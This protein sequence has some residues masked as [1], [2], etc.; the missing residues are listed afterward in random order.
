MTIKIE[1]S[2]CSFNINGTKDKDDSLNQ[3]LSNF[4][5]LFLQEHLLPLVSLNSLRRSKEHLVFA[6][7]A[8]KTS[9]RPSGG[10]ACVLK[11][12]LLPLSPVC[13]RECDY[14][15]AIRLANLVLINV[16]LPC[17]QRSFPSLTKYT[18]ACASLKTLL[19]SV[20]S[21]G[22]DWILL[23]DMNCDINSTSTRTDLF[24]DSLPNGYR[25]LDKD[26]SHS[27]IHNSGSLSDI[28]HC[29]V[30]SG[31]SISDIHIDQDERDYDHLPLSATVTIN[32]T[33]AEQNLCTNYKKW[34]TKRDWN[35]ADWPLYLSTLALLL[36]T[37]KVPFNL[38]CTSVI[39][40]QA[41][42]QLNIYYSQIVSCLKKAEEVA[43][44]LCRFKLKTRGSIW[45][46]DP[47][48]KIVKNRAKL[49]LRIW[50]AC[51]RPLRGHLFD[52]KQ[53]T[54][55]EFKRYLRKVR[56]NGV[57]FPKTS[58]QWK[59]V[60]N[61][62]KFDSPPNADRIPNASW[63]NHYNK[64]FNI[65]N[66]AVHSQ[67]V[68]LCSYVL[69][70]KI[71][72]GHVP[73]VS[74]D[75]VIRCVK[76]LK[77]KSCDIDGISVF[78][79][80]IDSKELIYHLQL[81]FQICL[82]TSL[83]PDSFLCGSVT[84]ILKRGKD[85]TNCASYRPIT[86]ACSLSK[87]FEYVLLPEILPNV[88]YVSNQ[89]GFKPNI[90]C[91]HAHRILTS[92]LIQAQK[93]GSEVHL[94]ALDISK[95]FDSVCH[96]QLWY[97]LTQLG[98][99]SSVIC[100]LRFWYANSYVRLRSGEIFF[101]NIPIR[102]GLRQGGVLSPYLFNACLYPVL[103]RIFPSCFTGLTNL[104]YIAYADDLL[105]ISRSKF[106]LAKSTQFVSK[107]L[108]KIGLVLNAEKCEY[109]VFNAK[110]PSSDLS[111]SSFSVKL[112]PALR[113]LGISICSSISAIRAS[114]LADI[115]NKLKAGY[116][117]I[118]PNRGRHS[119]KALAKLYSTY[120][121]HSILFLSGLRPFFNNNDM[122]D[123]RVLYFRYCK[124]L[125]YLPRWYR[126]RKIIRMF[127][128]TD[129]L[130]SYNKLDSKLKD[131]ACKRLGPFHPLVRLF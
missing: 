84:S 77:S 98:V 123:I 86:V 71:Y 53:K 45:K 47:D 83:V 4:D 48:L 20:E 17:D 117:K 32:T 57:E 61:V 22:L 90:G 93:D 23:G 24:L 122:Q 59:Q 73:P 68:S 33:R 126:N 16:Y 30:S 121:D 56:Y 64:I 42:V 72:Q 82:C 116:A 13:Y 8:R 44:P 36:S 96:S 52:I 49:W 10:L 120:C 34:I 119:R 62:A 127:N 9:G 60:I 19:I 97:S 50:V 6:R 88:D 104:S 112:A 66:Y 79:L 38:L 11:H 21:N 76:N 124:Y 15:I 101:G 63:I 103:S 99:N 14:F 39:S 35:K 115:K 75:R 70:A 94:C 102:S 108:E 129:I 80:H 67:F 105:L 130:T 107:L 54:K 40:P 51:G 111:C 37:I 114:A 29:V 81:L 1:F 65:M 113:W 7:S 128:A 28:D 46:S 25:V 95:A 69:P 58:S 27:Y 74:A 2:I 18:K 31:V 89:F 118:V 43:V 91:Q 55:L 106:T 87:V 26:A 5:I 92:F 110:N 12:K 125:L 78:H 131:E 100:V 85:P 109:L 3:K 41:R